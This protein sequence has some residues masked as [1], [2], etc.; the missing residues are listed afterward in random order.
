MVYYMVIKL[1]IIYIIPIK[2]F[3][4]TNNKQKT[5]NIFHKKKK[6]LNKN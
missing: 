5:Y 2:R 1:K 4:H 6:K 3:V